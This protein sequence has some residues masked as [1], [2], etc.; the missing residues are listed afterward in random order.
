MKKCGLCEFDEAIIVAKIKSKNI[1]F[2]EEVCQSCLLS[3]GSQFLSKNCFGEGG[4]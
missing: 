1:F 4:K 3:I 2:E